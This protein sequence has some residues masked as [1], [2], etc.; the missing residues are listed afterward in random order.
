[1]PVRCTLSVKPGETRPLVSHYS[2]PFGSE[3]FIALESSEKKT[4]QAEIV[5]LLGEYARVLEDLSLSTETEIF[6]RFYL[7]DIVTQAPLLRRLLMDRAAVSFLSF[8]GQPPASGNRCALQAY[9]IASKSPVIKTVKSNHMLSAR[10]GS[11][12]SVWTRS[13]P[14]GQARSIPLQTTGLFKNLSDDLALYGASLHEHLVRTWIFIRN[15]DDHYPAFAEAR[16]VFY[17]SA[18]LTKAT[19]TPVSTGIGGAAEEPSHLVFMDSL[20]VKGL[21]DGQIEYMSAPEYLCP[22]YSYNVTFERALRI[23]FGDRIHYHISGTASIDCEGNIVGPGDIQKQAMRTLEN[24]QALLSGYGAD[25]EDMRLIVVYLRDM[26][27]FP[28]IN[29]FLS[30]HLPEGVPYSIVR[31]KICRK[32]WLVEMDG[33]AIK[34]NSDSRF[35]PYC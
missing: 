13:S 23:F 8:V 12:T 35:A 22:A 25:L 10:H 21:A 5:A 16:R 30:G 15:I 6:I 2:T 26:E 24:I 19:H 31:G 34:P 4:S 32:A 20:A 1:M 33:I 17:S 28:A 3:T 29:S 18:G 7:S 14:P 11:Y 27:D 9:H